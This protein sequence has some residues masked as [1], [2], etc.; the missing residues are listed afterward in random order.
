M[1]R[2]WLAPLIVTLIALA[3]RLLYLA[4]IDDSPLWVLLIGDAQRYDAWA[5]Q[6]AAGAWLG[7]KV[8]YQAPLY[9]YF[10]AVIYVVA[11]H[12]LLAVRLVQVLLGALACGLLSVAGQRWFEHSPAVARR[13]GW[14]AG[15][16]MALYPPA[17]FFDGLIQK[18]ALDSFLMACLLAL[19]A[20]TLR[21]T[22]RTW[23]A[24]LPLGLVLG[25]L[26]LT[27]ENALVFV[28]CVLA[29]AVLGPVAH[30]LRGRAVAA[31][32][33]VLGLALTLLP[34]AARNQAVGGEFHLTTSQLG[35]NFS[36]GNRAGADGSYTPLRFAR[37][38]AAFEADDARD[39]AQQQVG[40]PL[41]PG[42]V[43][44]Y[45]LDRALDD[46][47]AD[48][49]R[50]A[51]LL[52]RKAILTITAAEVGDT[53]DQ[54]TYAESSW[55][56]RGLG[57]VWHM[58]VL[59]PLAVLGAVMTWP[60]W[61]RLWVLH[62][63]IVVYAASVIAF[64]VFARYRLPLAPMLML[65]AAGG[66]A[67]WPGCGSSRWW[68]VAAAVIAAVPANWP[69]VDTDHYRGMTHHNIAVEWMNQQGQVEPALEHLAVA[70]RLAPQYAPAHMA[71][72]LALTRLGQVEQALPH[73]QQA[74]ALRP[75]YADA[76]YNLGLALA[77][78]GRVV[79][80][81]NHYA[82][83][84]QLEPGHAQAANA[85]GLLLARAGQ[86]DEAIAQYQ[87]AVAAQPDF[88]EVHNNLGVAL[89]RRGRLDEAIAAFTQAL[90]IKPDY[91]DAQANLRRATE[92]K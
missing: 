85:L 79:E 15:L 66:L 31:G 77:K 83:A 39:L 43:S 25:A 46:I 53:E 86:L 55:L 57:T 4:Q 51:R 27:R 69:V 50:W 19:L 7:D 71:M 17:I 24:W 60:Q 80:A 54:Y 34:V 20:T 42:E 49:P 82:Q 63:L 26:A 76:H 11:G 65:L 41:S 2:R 74:L 64:Y 37:G 59:L 16:L 30:S 56:L 45:W 32:L 87:R 88:A 91:A 38:N 73:Y 36:I 72:G 28:P 92:G 81:A 78:L 44:D 89:A 52:A 1:P 5:R 62:A 40:R 70:L 68:A 75:D 18:S 48:P 61:R 29:W 58:G 12:S 22:W 33:V 10:L 47:A 6:I 23:R 3:V 8:F 35:P 21:R 13:A 84:Q 14:I 9:P 90:R 67:S